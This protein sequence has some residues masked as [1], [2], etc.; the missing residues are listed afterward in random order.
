MNCSGTLKID[1]NLFFS[2]L[3]SEALWHLQTRY[4]FVSV[5][6]I[7]T[8]C[9]QPICNTL[10]Y[11]KN[12][13]AFSVL[14]HCMAINTYITSTCANTQDVFSVIYSLCVLQQ[15]WSL[16][17]PS[18]TRNIYK[19]E[20]SYFRGTHLVLN[21]DHHSFAS[22]SLAQELKKCFSFSFTDGKTSLPKLKE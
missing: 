20:V 14:Y 9:N 1:L 4:K 6:F 15:F 17:L 22:S 7:P 19:G 2:G 10:A 3:Y 13:E 5:N 8:R 11:L 18:F 16:P 12:C 21:N